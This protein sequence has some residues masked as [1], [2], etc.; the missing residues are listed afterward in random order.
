MQLPTRDPTAYKISAQKL[1]KKNKFYTTD[2]C[3]TNFYSCHMFFQINT[4]EEIKRKTNSKSNF[5]DEKFLKR[6]S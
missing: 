5:F 3:D 6:K 2:L 1:K 4:A